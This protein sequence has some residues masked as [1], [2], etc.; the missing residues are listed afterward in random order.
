MNEPLAA[1]ERQRAVTYIGLLILIAVFSA[2]TQA[3][4]EFRQL[5]SR[6]QADDELLFFSHKFEQAL[7]SYMYSTP[8][9]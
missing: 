2:A 8:A 5:I 7:R 4:I 6:R 3:T 9:G 1:S